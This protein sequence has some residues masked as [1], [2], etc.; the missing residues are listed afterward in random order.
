MALL[1]HTK[2]MTLTLH[3]HEHRVLVCNKYS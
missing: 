2:L 3:G 1:A